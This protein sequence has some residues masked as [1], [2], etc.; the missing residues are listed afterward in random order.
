MHFKIVQTDSYLKI[1]TKFFK[2]HSE[3]FDKY[4]KTVTLLEIDPFHPS[5]RLH[6]LQGKLREYHSLSIDMSYRIVIEFMI[7][8]SEI[9]LINIGSHDDVYR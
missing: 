8:D 2:K 7:Q 6:K 5:L 3:L 1:A 9:I 4:A